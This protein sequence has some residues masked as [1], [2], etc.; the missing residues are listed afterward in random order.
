MSA[1]IR[2][3]V[4]SFD[5]ANG[6]SRPFSG[7][8]DF[9]H[10]ELFPV[11]VTVELN[12]TAP[13]VMKQGSVRQGVP[14]ENQIRNLRV[15]NGSG[16]TATIKL[17]MGTGSLQIAG[18]AVIVG[19]L[20]L[21]SGASTAALQTTGNNSLASILAGLAALATHALQTAG[22]ALLTTIAGLAA[23][24]AEVPELIV[25]GASASQEFSGCRSISILNT[26]TGAVNVTVTTPGGARTL[27]PGQSVGW[28][29]TK[30]LATLS[31]V[32]VATAASGSANVA[33][34]T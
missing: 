31:S 11:G 22:N 16:S 27:A 15:T 30:P 13:M 9:V 10:F 3:Q 2:Q 20:P 8:F 24:T 21:P 12:E 28:S 23:T 18:E 19:A 32:T 7:E 26:N 5:L 17:V 33:Y 25:L 4:E 1:P 29:V 34:T 14:G 6:A